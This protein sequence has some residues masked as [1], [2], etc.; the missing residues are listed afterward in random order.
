M[1]SCLFDLF[2]GFQGKTLQTITTICDNRPILQRCSPQAKHPPD[3]S[4]LEARKREQ[5]LW[6]QALI[7]WNHEVKM[8]EIP[9]KMLSRKRIIAGARAGT[10]VVCPVIALLQWKSEVAKFTEQGNLTVGIYH[11]P[12]RASETTP[13]MLSKYDVVLTTYQC[14]EQDFRKMVSPNKGKPSLKGEGTIFSSFSCSQLP[15]RFAKQ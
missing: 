5:K 8:N 13:E 2:A 11:G 10:L 4:D 15:H 9:K 12:N 6:E 14:L 7:E 1:S 3:A